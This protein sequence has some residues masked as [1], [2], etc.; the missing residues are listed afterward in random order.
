MV[1]QVR[2]YRNATW[3]RA[4]HET[5]VPSMIV[6]QTNKGHKARVSRGS[7]AHGTLVRRRRHAALCINVTQYTT[8]AA[9]Y[10][11]SVELEG[12]N[13]KRRLLG[14]WRHQLSRARSRGA[15]WGGCG[16]GIHVH[17]DPSGISVHARRLAVNQS[18]CCRLARTF[19]DPIGMADDRGLLIR[20]CAAKTKMV[21][22]IE[23]SRS[24]HYYK[25]TALE[26][27]R[28]IGRASDDCPLGSVVFSRRA[29]HIHAI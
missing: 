2:D 3:S 14:E 18:S 28:R 5:P 21:F 29:Q 25:R 16:W 10:A 1:R 11:L 27:A 17:I 20:G 23:K 9:V 26:T 12:P 19:L 4:Y 24:H 22:A 8:F 13:H 7:F 6:L 15:E